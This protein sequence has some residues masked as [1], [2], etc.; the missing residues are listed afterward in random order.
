M[1]LK[2]LLAAS[3][4]S[5]SAA[6]TI[7]TPAAAQQITSGVEGSVTDADGNSLTG[8]VVTVTDTRTGSTRTSTTGANGSFRIQSLQ[9]GGPYTVTV[10]ADGYEGQTVEDVFTNI[11]G[12][13]GFNFALDATAAGAADNVIVVTGA[14]AQVSQVA[15]GPGTA[16]GTETLEAFPSITRDVRDI[17]RIDP[18]VSIDQANDVDRISCLGGNDRSNTFTVDGIVQADVFGLNGTPFAARNSLPLPFDVVDQVSVEFAPF[19]VEYSEFTGCLVN[20]VTKSGGNKF[21]GSAF[22][23]YFDEG[24]FADNLDGRQ[25]SANEEKRWGATLSGPIIPDRLFFSFGYEE[26]DLGQGNNVGPTGG[27]FADEENFVTQAQFDEFARIARD[28]YGQ[29]IGGYPTSLAEGNVRYFGRLDAI[30]TDDHRLEATYQRLEETNVE[31]D[32]GDQNLGGLNSFE[33]EGTISDYYSV[34]LY[35]TWSDTIS[36]ELRLS[37]AEVGDVQGP[38]G[39]GEA[40]SDDPTVRL[41][42]GVAPVAG[43][44]TQNGILSTGPGIF[45]S[46]NQLDT[47]I[48]QA[49]FQINVDAGNDHFLKFG[50]EI[51][52]LEVFNLF[53]INATGTLYFRNLAD[54]ENGLVA[55]GNFSSVFGDV[56]DELID[57]NSR[58]QFLGGGV[59]NA[60]P[61]GDINEAAA[62]FS[63][64]IYSV[65]AQDEWQ[66]T[67]RLS[68]NA[69]VRVQ[70]YDGDAPTAN[71]EFLRRYGFTNANSF[72]RIDT[73]VLPRLSATYEFDNDGFFSNS[74][75]TGGVGMF[76]GG[77]PV[78]YFSNAFSNNGFS[79]GEGSTF[80]SSCAGVRNPNGSFSVLQNGQ[81]AGFPQCAINAGS[82]QAAAGLSDTQSTDPEFD[83]PTVVR[84]NVGFQTDFGTE[85]GFFSDWRLSLDYIYSRFNDTLNFVDLSQTPDIR[86]N[87]GFTVDG[88]PIYAA[89]D[90]TATG[91]NAVLAGTGGTPPVY[92]NVTAACFSTRRDDEIQ[93][94]NGPSY[95]S[96]VFSAILSKN[97]QGGLFTSGG[98]TRINLGYAFTD[99]ENNRNNGS[100]TATSSYDITTAFDRQD[101]AVST[102]NF[103]NRHNFTAAVNFREEF[104]EGYDTNIGFFFRARSGLPYSL[105][106]DGGGV[107]NDS[108]SGSDNALL[109]IPTGVGD[110]N[111]SP[112]SDPAAVTALLNYLDTSEV[113]SQCKF[114]PGESIARNTCNN[115]WFFDLDMRI[116][117]ELP[118][119]GS[120]TGI[121][122][123][124][125]EVFADFS[126][127]L[128]LLDSSWNVLRARGD[129]VDLVDG[130]VDAQGRYII[131]GF[132]PDDQNFLSIGQSAWRIQIGARYEF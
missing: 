6:T 126:N 15:V 30:I 107:F 16:F 50:A 10:T 54:F 83:V 2:Y 13:T 94:T 20:V 111:I 125:I 36:T 46:A 44:T 61:S 86:T 119:L 128:N 88:R 19:D 121:T 17:I 68:I 53:A 100:S 38:V 84:A 70:L 25:L 40:Q 69:G 14:R 48:D 1:K 45:R 122:E 62:L 49:R 129:F 123:D 37:R 66:A 22:I 127:F 4:V 114:T 31:P 89:I 73:V 85:T 120:L 71:P 24:L 92:S 11:S 55:S 57:G 39:F 28:V 101:P 34:R 64:R 63:R 60:T 113:G 95:D 118:F 97:F 124:R 105:T 80:S 41:V 5:L 131:S 7:A 96:H 3:V 75:L 115:D 33:D 106:F 91:C 104:F 112:S 65:Y 26:A 99:S 72:G 43:Q 52:D 132:N 76:T 93:L 74:R 110:P 59:I 108:S 9:P 87:G 35:S 116:S 98:G 42:V 23:T 90:P 102:S 78:V 51:N 32:F 82:A 77:D 12:N 81:F 8:A 29:D 103:E 47:K 58:G 109:Y 56:A 27:G 18:R 130:G 79:T 117:Q 67:D 21:S